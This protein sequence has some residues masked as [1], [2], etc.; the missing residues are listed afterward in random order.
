MKATTVV[1]LT[2]KGMALGA[3]LAQGKTWEEAEQLLEET[4]QTSAPA[5][6]VFVPAPGWSGGGSPERCFSGA[7][8]C[9]NNGRSAEKE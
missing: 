9:D 5:S 7:G 3:L 2:P 8:L 4:L 1:S 6:D